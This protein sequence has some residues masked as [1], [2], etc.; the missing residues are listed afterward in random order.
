MKYK[1]PYYQ[2]MRFFFTEDKSILKSSYVL[3]GTVHIENYDI[4]INVVTFIFMGFLADEITK[5][6]TNSKKGLLSVAI[7]LFK[8]NVS[9][10]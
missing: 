1:T 8:E 5:F 7:N 4:K 2:K 10:A 6:Y 3:K 9:F